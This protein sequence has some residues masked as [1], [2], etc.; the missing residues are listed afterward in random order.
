[1]DLTEKQK[2]KILLYLYSAIGERVIDEFEDGKDYLLDLVGTIG[3]Q[4]IEDIRTG[5]EMGRSLS[6]I[7]NAANMLGEDTVLSSLPGYRKM[8]DVLH[9]DFP[10]DNS[11]DKKIE[12]SL[13]SD[14]VD[15]TLKYG[16]AKSPFPVHIK[17]RIIE[18]LSASDVLYYRLSNDD[19]EG[20]RHAAIDEMICSLIA[21]PGLADFH[22]VRYKEPDIAFRRSEIRDT[23][24][25]RR[26][27]RP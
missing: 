3:V 25:R 5:L 11:D 16:D 15:I 21:V 6:N 1:M 2:D 22:I 27:V 26:K 12:L 23:I 13:A 4:A 14:L 8:M 9:S 18:I 19:P 17:D 10:V 20:A 7:I 24:E